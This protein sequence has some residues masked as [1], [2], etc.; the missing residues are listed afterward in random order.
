MRCTHVHV[1][2]CSSSACV[3]N[4]DQCECLTDRGGY[5]GVCRCR[6]RTDIVIS[7]CWRNY[8]V[9]LFSFRSIL[10][11]HMVAR[12]SMAIWW[13]KQAVF[14]R[15]SAC[16]MQI[17]TRPSC[18]A[19]AHCKRFELWIGRPNIFDLLAIGTFYFNLPMVT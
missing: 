7:T 8:G 15:H 1:C 3:Y 4:H 11:P 12:R 14:L 18:R 10:V 9:C 17:D 16:N 19:A 13:R 5:K 2:V 6:C